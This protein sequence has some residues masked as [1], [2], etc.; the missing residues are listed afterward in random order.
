MLTRVT[1]IEFT[2]PTRTGRTKPAILACQAPDGSVVEVV[3]KFS[4]GCDQREVNLAREVIAACLAGDLGLPVS[5]PFLI[6]LPAEFVSLVPDAGQRTRIAASVPVAF[7]SRHLSGQVS[8]WNQRTRL[9][10]SMVPTAAAILAF[11]GIVQNADR[12]ADNPNCLVRGTELRIFDHELTFSHGLV[13]GWTPPWRLGGLSVLEVP[14]YHAFRSALRGQAV[15]YRPIRA[16]WL[17]LSD[18]RISAYGGAIP[19][20]WAAASGAVSGA[21]ALIRDARDNID[22]CLTEVQRVLG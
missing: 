4:A 8:A 7:G 15:D 5:E 11:D 2:R 16:A 21:L 6:D 18:S 17:A 22:A 3:A 20:E 14:G 12:R 13:I 19:P 9:L 10:P 1:A